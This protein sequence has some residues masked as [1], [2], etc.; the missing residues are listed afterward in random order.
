MQKQKIILTN[1]IHQNNPVVSFV[2]E[3][4]ATLINKVKTLPGARWSQS[5]RFWYIP[6]EQFTLS[7]VFDA[8][9]PVAYLDYSAL[10]GGQ[11]KPEAGKKHARKKTVMLADLSDQHQRELD[12]FMRWMSQQRYKNLLSENERYLPRSEQAGASD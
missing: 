5:R 10:K 11:K 2:F 12:G 8:L 3:K 6:K 9:Q 7:M 4:D 1:E